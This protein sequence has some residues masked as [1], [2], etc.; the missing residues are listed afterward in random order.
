[1]YVTLVSEDFMLALM[2]VNGLPVAIEPDFV[3]SV[4]AHP[5]N[6]GLS[7]IRMSSGREHIIQRSYTYVTGVIRSHYEGDRAA[8]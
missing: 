5:D 2:K 1:V 8:H 6:Q 7:V 3:E 4:E